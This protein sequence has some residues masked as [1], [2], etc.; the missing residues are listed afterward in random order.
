MVL[1]NKSGCWQ[2]GLISVL[3]I[4][5][6]MISASRNYLLAQIVSDRTLGNETSAIAPNAEV[7]GLP[8]KLG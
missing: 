7:K 8:A 5:E 2:L 3:L 4:S 6:A 1:V